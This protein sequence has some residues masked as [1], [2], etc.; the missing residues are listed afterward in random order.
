MAK[1]PEANFWTSLRQSLPTTSIGTRIENKAGGGIP[2][3]HILLDGLPLW[4]ELK[5]T[6]SARVSVSPHQVAWHTAYFARGGLSGF[7]VKHLSS[8]NRGTISFFSGSQAIDVL[9]NGLKTEPLFSVHAAPE[10]WPILRPIVRAFYLDALRPCG[11]ATDLEPPQ[12]S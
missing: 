7:L 12:G 11:P 8:K 5:V 4:V 9:Q 1:G 3:A 10:V 2:D 6:A